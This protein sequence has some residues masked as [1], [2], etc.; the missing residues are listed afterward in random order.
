M[1]IALLVAVF[2]ANCAPLRLQEVAIVPPSTTPH[3]E[4][5]LVYGGGNRW[6]DSP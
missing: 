4:V 2:G 1:G 3:A 6:G 5:G